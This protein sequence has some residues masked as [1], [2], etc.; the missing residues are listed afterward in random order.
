[1][2]MPLVVEPKADYD[3]WY[4]DVMKKALRGWRFRRTVRS[5][6]PARQHRR[7]RQ[8]PCADRHGHER[9]ENELRPWVP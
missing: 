8:R 4:A 3:A 2:Q 7:E 1:M 5:K 6:L 9:T